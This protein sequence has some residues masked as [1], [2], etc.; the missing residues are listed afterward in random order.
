MRQFLVGVLAVAAFAVA[1]GLALAHPPPNH[2]HC[3]TTP[4]GKTHAIAPGVTLHAP[5]ETAF[6]NFHQ[7][8]HREVFG[9]VEIG[10][11]GKHPLGPIPVNLPFNP[12]NPPC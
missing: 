7:N 6:H 3:L 4:S 2:L 10:L 12:A 8:V 9:V 11:A 1:S 5:H